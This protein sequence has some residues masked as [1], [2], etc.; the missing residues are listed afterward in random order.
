MTLKNTKGMRKVAVAAASAAALVGFAVPASA[1]EPLVLDK[2]DILPQTGPLI[3]TG[4]DPMG[5]MG[6]LPQLGADRSFQLTMNAG[7]ELSI[8]YGIP[9]LAPENTLATSSLP[10]ALIIA[11]DGT[12]TLLQPNM[13]VP[14]YND[15]F[16]QNYLFLNQYSTTA[17]AGTYSVVLI[18][19]APERVFVA[20]GVEDSG[21]HGIERGSLAT[22]AQVDAWYSTL[23]TDPQ[24]ACDGN[25]SMFAAKG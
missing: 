19:R 21:F 12:P 9:D 16:D 8:G 14:L 4:T 10:V 20:T 2:C 15:D 18:G 1:H 3:P 25:G 17:K 24:P 13:R 5:I 7:D 22:D 11:P 6:T 23:P